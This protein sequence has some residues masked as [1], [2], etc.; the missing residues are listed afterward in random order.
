MA[1]WA[2]AKNIPLKAL[3]PLSYKKASGTP[4]VSYEI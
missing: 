2:D 3:Q 1:F 4:V